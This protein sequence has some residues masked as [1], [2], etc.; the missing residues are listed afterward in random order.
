MARFRFVYAIALILPGLASNLPAQ[1][2]PRPPEVTSPEILKDRKVAFRIHA[3]NA[4]SVKL[5]GGDLPNVNQ[6]IDLKPGEKGVW[7]AIVGPVLP[8][9]YR[10]NL[11]IDGVTI[12]DPKNTSTSESN[13]NLWSLVQVP[14]NDSFDTK[15]IPHGALAQVHYYSSTLKRLRRAH[16]YTP[17]G[18]EAGT[19]KYPV[20]YLLHGAMDSDNSWSTVGR[21]GIILD[22]LIASGKA[23]PMIVVMP[24]GHTGPFRFGPPTG[25]NSFEKQMNDFND[26]FARDLRP[27]IEKSYR[28]KEGKTNRA[29]AGLS[30]GGAQTLN[31]AIPKL[32]DYAWLGVYSSGVFGIAGGFGGQPDTSW[33]DKHKAFLDNPEGKKDLKLVWFA[34]GKEDFLL[35]TTKATV[36]M[37]KK[38]GF[39]VVYKETDG[40]H[41]WPK[42]RDYLVEFAPQ[43]FRD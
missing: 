42:W 14:G 11:Q 31:I 24:M 32:E 27:Y 5:T 20:F 35:E 37:L 43:L 1:G 40:G 23:K 6:G 12:L 2:P 30:M 15:N 39:D 10:Y 38:H 17:P 9:A 18:Y 36:A 3:P 34:T 25:E 33:V 19:E 26:D 28:L 16:V 7:E 41:T 22:N 29:I 4:K 13:G 8:G 21:A